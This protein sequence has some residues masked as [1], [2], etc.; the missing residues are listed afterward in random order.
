MADAK[1]NTAQDTAGKMSDSVKVDE[2][3][4]QGSTN[5]PNTPS[6]VPSRQ[7][8]HP[9]RNVYSCL[10]HVK[11]A[12][13]LLLGLAAVFFSIIVVYSCEFFSYRTLDGEPWEGL[14]APFDTLSSARVGLFSF[15]S[16][17]GNDS[18]EVSFLDG[19]CEEYDNPWEAGQ[20]DYWIIAQWCAVVAPVAGFLAFIQLVWEMILCRL[21]CSFVLITLLFLAASGL[22]GCSFMVFADT[23]FW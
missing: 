8:Q 2:N 13:I 18:I 16:A 7:Q 5:S 10:D 21:R 4:T 14:M 20:S 6:Q 15:S 9:S 19:E 11:R 1:R 3:N 12:Y 22:Q 17:V 23:E